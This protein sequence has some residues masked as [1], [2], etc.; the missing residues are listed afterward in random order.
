VVDPD[1]RPQSA[2]ELL[3]M[4]RNVKNDDER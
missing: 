2:E 1:K 4:I 3:K